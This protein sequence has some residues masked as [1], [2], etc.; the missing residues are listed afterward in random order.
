MDISVVD[1]KRELDCLHDD[2][3]RLAD[4]TNW[5][6]SWS[7]ASAW[8]RAFGRDDRQLAILRC[9]QADETVAIL[10][11]Y[12]EHSFKCGRVLRFVGSDKACGD[13]LD[14]ICH[15]D[16]AD[17]AARHLSDYLLSTDCP[18]AWDTIS[19][20]GVAAHAWKGAAVVQLLSE[21][22]CGVDRRSIESAWRLNLQGSLADLFAAV[23]ETDTQV[24]SHTGSK[25]CSIRQS[26][27]AASE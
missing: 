13:Y 24:P 3:T 7:W 25:V 2:W 4:P 26:E 20:E 23:V 8:W 1:N 18:L 19:L 15:P 5:F 12:S 6:Q 10:P 21:C 9:T 22:G 27:V 11:L 16:N 14:L 17:D